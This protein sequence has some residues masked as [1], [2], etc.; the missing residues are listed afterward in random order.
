MRRK[1]HR[2]RR[3]GWRMVWGEEKRRDSRLFV[4][5][6]AALSQSQ[7]PSSTE[8]LATVSISLLHLQPFV[9]PSPLH[10]LQIPHHWALNRWAIPVPHQQ[11]I[12]VFPPPFPLFWPLRLFSCPRASGFYDA[13]EMAGADHN[14]P[15]GPRMELPPA[16]GRLPT[17]INLAMAVMVLAAR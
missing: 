13:P 15:P 17:T 16:A 8:P 6:L 3:L 4:L 2:I 12:I 5:F 14:R 11:P 7:E 10:N 9:M 1:G